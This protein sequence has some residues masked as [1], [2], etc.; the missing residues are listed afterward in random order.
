MKNCSAVFGRAVADLSITMRRIPSS[1]SDDDLRVSSTVE[2]ENAR[3]WAEGSG[4]S[5]DFLLFP[6]LD[7]ASLAFPGLSEIWEFDH[8]LCLAPTV[9]FSCWEVSR[10]TL[11]GGV[12][13]LNT[14]AG[15][16]CC[17]G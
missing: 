4:G 9:F 7:R 5:P 1:S 14:N 13:D 2:K 6:M 3:V 12:G 10:G 8:M 15:G 11:S 17:R 16:I